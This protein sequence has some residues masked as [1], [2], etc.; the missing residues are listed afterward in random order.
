MKLS[1]YQSFLFLFMIINYFQCQHCFSYVVDQDKVFKRLYNAVEQSLVS[2]AP[3]LCSQVLFNQNNAQSKYI[4]P[5]GLTGRV[6][7]LGTFTS[8]ILALEYLYGLVCPA[9]SIPRDNVLQKTDITRVTYDKKYLIAHVEFIFIL[10]NGKRLTFSVS[11]AFDQN[12]KL[13]GY[14]GQVQ[15]AGLTLDTYTDHQERINRLCAG[16]QIFCNG[17]LQQYDSVNACIQYLTTQ[18]PY[19]SYDRGD[20]GNVV[21][22]LIHIL[23]VPLLPSVHCPHVGPTGGEACFDKT[24]DYYYNQTDFLACAHKYK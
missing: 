3:P 17:T 19:G 21:C 15:N 9:T 8:T 23:L 13:C 4:S 11:A 16:I 10:T 18:V 12:Y 22:R 6:L 2:F 14:D 20:Q 7:P 1:C 5:K 24:P